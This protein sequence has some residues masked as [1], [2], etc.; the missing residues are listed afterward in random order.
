M[1]DKKIRRSWLWYLWIVA[2]ASTLVGLVGL[3]TAIQF[4]DDNLMGGW[5]LLFGPIYWLGLFLVVVAFA[6]TLV[7][8]WR[9]R[10]RGDIK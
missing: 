3:L 9:L 4:Y 6:S 10:H 1:E 2:A 5:A 8:F 7:K